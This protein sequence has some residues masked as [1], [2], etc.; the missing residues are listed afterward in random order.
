MLSSFPTQTS[1]KKSNNFNFSQNDEYEIAVI[2][3]PDTN[4]V[5]LWI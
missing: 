5:A 4:R 3:M 1:T 2:T